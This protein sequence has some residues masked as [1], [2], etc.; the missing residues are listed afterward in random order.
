MF[1]SESF[2]RRSSIYD[3]E[4]LY[5]HSE[6]VCLGGVAATRRTATRD[7]RSRHAVAS[8]RGS[9]TEVEFELQ[10]KVQA[11]SIPDMFAHKVTWL[12]DEIFQG[13]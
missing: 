1:L 10:L 5:G 13:S 4:E 3:I 7:V 8:G 11:P 12:D 2:V 6:E 9:P